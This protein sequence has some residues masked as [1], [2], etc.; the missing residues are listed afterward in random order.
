MREPREQRGPEA[1][2]AR[3]SENRVR[4]TF[5]CAMGSLIKLPNATQ[6][7][8]MVEFGIGYSFVLLLFAGT[9]GFGH[10][11]HV[12]NSAQSAVRS[13]ARFASLEAYDLPSGTEWST[14]VKNMAVYGT[15]APQCSPEPIVPNFST[16]NIAVTANTVSGVPESVV[17]EADFEVQT[18]FFSFSLSHPRVTF[19]YLGQIVGP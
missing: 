5:G 14:A 9:I 3:V 12:Y 10:L 7:H 15:P 8:V 2:Q 17:V 13:A 6:G 18:P 11:F 1:R 16:T 4:T 19:P